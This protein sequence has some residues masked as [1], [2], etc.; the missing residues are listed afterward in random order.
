LIAET[1]QRA[2]TLSS[3][4]RVMENSR[5]AD[6]FLRPPVEEFGTFDFNAFAAAAEVGYTYAMDRL[7][8]L[9]AEGVIRD[10]AIIRAAGYTGVGPG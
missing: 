5:L 1:V 4:L 6:I 7:R 9:Q 2:M 10:G 8:Q 3:T